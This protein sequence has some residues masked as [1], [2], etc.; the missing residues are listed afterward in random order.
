MPRLWI[1][2]AVSTLAGSLTNV[3]T[4]LTVVTGEGTRFPAPA[5]GEYFVATLEEVDGGGA[6]VGRERVR[7]TARTTDTLTVERGVEGTTARAFPAGSRVELRVTAAGMANL[8]D[9]TEPL[10]LTAQSAAPSVPAAGFFKLYARTRAGRTLPEFIG[11]SGVDSPLQPAMFGNRVMMISPG[12]GTA[13][14]YVGLTGSSAG[15]LS[16]PTLAT[17]SLATTLYRTRFQT[18][19]TNNAGAGV[20]DNVNTV[21]R[22]NAA[23]R[24]GFFLHNR[25][26]TGDLALG[27]TEVIV[28]LSSQ[29]GALAG[30]PDAL[31]DVL[32]LVKRTGDTTWQLIRRTGTGTAQ[33]VN[34]GHT[35]AANQV[36]DHVMFAAPGASGVT[37][38]FVLQNFDGTATLITEQTFTDNLPANTTFLSRHI[39]IRNGSA[40]A[41]NIEL[42]RSYLES[43]F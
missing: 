43:D 36:L 11:P 27:T 10:L 25:I 21:W 28:G 8:A 29:T 35:Y 23:G 14:T 39:G 19:T 17:T 7:C 32:G 5:A 16:H 30:T 26:C 3:A 13:V 1:D 40:A 24:G 33:L 20:R 15:T 9:G 41:A 12:S 37:M 2:H 42:V 6:V 18:A 31:P 4:S 34:T 38:R 22:G